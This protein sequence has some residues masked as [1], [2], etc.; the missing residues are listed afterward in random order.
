MGISTYSG[1]WVPDNFS[2][3]REG[4]ACEKGCKSRADEDFLVKVL[5]NGCNSFICPGVPSFLI[6]IY[7]YEIFFFLIFLNV[8]CWGML[9]WPT[10]K[11]D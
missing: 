7:I 4:E 2:L 9:V 5:G 10:L 1:D 8:I 3:Q 11:Y 6:F